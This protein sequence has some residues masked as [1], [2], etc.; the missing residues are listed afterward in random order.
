MTP[1]EIQ[2]ADGKPLRSGRRRKRSGRGVR[3][4]RASIALVVIAAIAVVLGVGFQIFHGA[5]HNG[6]STSVD[7]R[8]AVADAERIDTTDAPGARTARTVYPYSIVPGG[9]YNAEEAKKAVANDPVV[10]EHYRDF[11]LDVMH[12]ERVTRPR[13]VYLSYR[14]GNQ[15]YW[16][17]RP[18]RLEPGEL[19]LTD[20]REAVRARCGNRVSDSAQFPVAEREPAAEAFDQPAPIV[21]PEEP[22]LQGFIRLDDL[23]PLSGLD[24]PGE[25]RLAAVSGLGLVSATPAGLMGMLGL[26]ERPGSDDAFFFPADGAV[27]GFGRLPTST[28][29]DHFFSAGLD[30]PF[31][32]SFDG[33]G[34]GPGPGDGDRDALVQSGGGELHTPIPDLGTELRAASFVELTGSDIS[35]IGGDEPV[36]RDGSGPSDGPASGPKFPADTSGG[37]NNPGGPPP[38]VIAPSDVGDGVED[39]AAVPEPGTLLLVGSALAG[40][41]IFRRRARSGRP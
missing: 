10:A 29:A 21:V 34:P 27:G 7:E 19:L 18:V 40:A 6:P 17:K 33:G 16:T 36:V 32:D 11:A 35:T 13:A 31:A 39:V 24:V 37:P 5:F 22:S 14:L 25:P 28:A 3:R 41:A 26:S 38:G 4:R 1:I 23:A 15:V 30:A 12:V 8:L 9:V 2:D 20:G